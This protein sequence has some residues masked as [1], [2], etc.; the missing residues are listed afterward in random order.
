MENSEHFDHKNI[1]EPKKDEL[2]VMARK[3]AK[4]VATSQ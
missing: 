3:G 2:G 4:I 1:E